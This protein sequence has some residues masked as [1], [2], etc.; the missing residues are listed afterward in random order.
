MDFPT[1]LLLA[2]ALAMDAF[3]VALSAGGFLKKADAHQTFRLSFHFGLFQF[4]MPVLG[5]YAGEQF[6]RYIA[7]I[8]HWVVLVLLTVIGGRM[9]YASAHGGHEETKRDVTRGKMLVGLSFATSIDALAVGISLSMMN[10][11]I[12]FPSIVIGIV[13]GLMT[14]LGL[15]LGERFAARVGQ[16]MEFT[17]G[18]VLLCVGIKVVIEH[19]FFQ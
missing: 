3:V 8:D 1:T 14:I 18:I 17:A 10:T 16:R 9:M 4:L 6:T 19:V 5:W 11:R 2:F 13:A 15:R 12:I 7:F